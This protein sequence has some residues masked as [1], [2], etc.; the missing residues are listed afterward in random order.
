MDVVK[1]HSSTY[2]TGGVTDQ[3]RAPVG[4]DSSCQFVERDSVTTGLSE[5]VENRSPSAI[6]DEF[7]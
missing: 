6:V 3:C 2:V 7:E 4:N 1:L 5:S